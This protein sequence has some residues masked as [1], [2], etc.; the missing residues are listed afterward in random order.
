MTVPKFP[1]RRRGDVSS[2]ALGNTFVVG[3]NS[4]LTIAE[5]E[6]PIQIQLSENP[7][8]LDL[9]KGDGKRQ[10]LVR[11][12]ATNGPVNVKM[13]TY[14]GSGAGRIMLEIKTLE[15][16]EPVAESTD[17]PSKLTFPTTNSDIEV[18]GLDGSIAIRKINVSE[19]YT[20]K[21]P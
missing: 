21:V 6:E 11:V 3:W 4:P 16:P 2:S 1:R 17:L 20:G 14:R 9:R 19:G 5:S 18:V 13:R 15:S 8:D 7:L 10:A 12:R